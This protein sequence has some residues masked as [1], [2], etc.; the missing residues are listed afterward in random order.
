[1]VSCFRDCSSGETPRLTF[2]LVPPT[3][4]FISQDWRIRSIGGYIGSLIGVSPY[5]TLRSPL[6]VA[7]THA[8]TP[9]DLLHGRSPRDLPPYGT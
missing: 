6:S 5:S 8:P 3:A 2:V 7:D 9:L 4:C 1:M